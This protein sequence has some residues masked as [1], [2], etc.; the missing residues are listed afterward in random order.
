MPNSLQASNFPEVNLPNTNTDD[1]RTE[2]QQ[3][4]RS[5]RVET[6]TSFASRDD[7]DQSFNVC[8]K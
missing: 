5:S 2:K 4:M 6:I 3:D 8:E 1:S 7:A